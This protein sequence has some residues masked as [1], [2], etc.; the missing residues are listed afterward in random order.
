MRARAKI[1]S[2]QSGGG[3]DLAEPQSRRGA[4]VLGDLHRVEPEHDVGQHRP[5]DR[6]RRSGRR[7][8]RPGRGPVRPV[9]VRRPRHQSTADTTGLKWAPDTG[10]NIRISTP[11]PNTVASEFCSSCRPTSVGDSCWAAMPE[12]MTTATS[13]PVPRNSASSRRAQRRHGRSVGRAGRC[14]AWAGTCMS[15]SRSRTRRSMSS[16]M[17]RTAATS[18]PAGSSRSQS[19]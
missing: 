4:V 11:S 1:S 2:D 17:G 16:R 6:R 14:Q 15:S 9:P 18:S 19:T 12:P 10:P 5:G 3:D 8:R 13:S 7:C